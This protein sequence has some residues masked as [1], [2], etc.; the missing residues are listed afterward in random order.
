[1][2]PTLP[3][4]MHV[5]QRYPEWCCAYSFLRKFSCE[6]SMS[7]QHGPLM[8]ASRA[9]QTHGILCWQEDHDAPF[10]L[11]LTRQSQSWG[12][13]KVSWFLYS[14]ISFSQSYPFEH[15]VAHC[16]PFEIQGFPFST[17]FFALV[18]QGGH[19]LAAYLANAA[20]PVPLVLDLRIAHDRFGSISDLNLSG[21]LHYPNDM[22]KSLNET[23]ADKIRKY[24]S[25]YT[26][27]C[28]IYAC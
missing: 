3:G 8:S 12:A 27:V 6:L 28:R 9:L 19:S 25:D 17:F 22:D 13:E 24:R 23:A 14:S 16:R 4:K 15:R 10:F 11:W 21:Y 18:N 7:I 5:I 1:M 26:R 2:T 20:G